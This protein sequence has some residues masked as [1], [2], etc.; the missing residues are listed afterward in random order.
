MS[1]VIAIVIAVVVYLLM[2]K[3][4]KDPGGGGPHDTK[5]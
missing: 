2:F 5:R 3:G 1:L 4:K